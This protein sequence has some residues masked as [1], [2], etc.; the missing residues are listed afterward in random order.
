MF[1]IIAWKYHARYNEGKTS[2]PAIKFVQNPLRNKLRLPKP[3]T[4]RRNKL[5]IKIDQILK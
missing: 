5:V 4:I 2:K 3:I 1:E